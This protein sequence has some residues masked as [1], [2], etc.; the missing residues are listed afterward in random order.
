MTDLEAAWDEL[1]AAIPST[2]TVGRPSWHIEDRRWALYAW[3]TTE[4]VKVGKRSREW[5]AVGPTE[6]EV[7]QEMARCLREISEGRVPK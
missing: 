5:T 3:D 2:W 7:V 1:I 4:R 6:V